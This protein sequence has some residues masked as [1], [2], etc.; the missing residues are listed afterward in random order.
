MTN[1]N[2]GYNMN[3]KNKVEEEEKLLLMMLEQLSYI[4]RY[5]NESMYYGS[6]TSIIVAHILENLM[7]HNGEKSHEFEPKEITDIFNNFKDAEIQLKKM[8]L[9]VNDTEEILWDFGNFFEDLM[10]MTGIYVNKTD[11]VDKILLDY[12]NYY[13]RKKSES[14]NKKEK[15]CILTCDKNCDNCGYYEEDDSNMGIDEPSTDEIIKRMVL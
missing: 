2:V 5:V 1:I 11:Y 7:H 13:Y 10:I 8:H 3:N 14:V 4:M 9:A 6:K 12:K 15:N